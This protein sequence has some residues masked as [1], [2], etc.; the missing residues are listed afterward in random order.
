MDHSIE[1]LEGNKV[2][3]TVAVPADEFE[4]AI[5]AAFRKLAREVRIPG[6]RPGKAPRR[7][8][9]ARF[10]P[11]VAREHAL[12]DGLPEF[13]A[14]AVVAEDLDT[15]AAPEIEITAGE[16]AGDVEFEAVV[17]VRPVVHVAGYDSL[18][19]ELDYAA[20]DDAAIT[21]QLDGLRERFA[22]LSDSSEP[23]VDGDYAQIDLEGSVDGAPVD[24][25]SATDFLYEVGSAMVTPALDAQLRGTGPGAIL[26]FTD[27]LPERFGEQAGTEVAFRVLVKDAKHKVLPELTDAW[28]G[29]VTEFQ[30]VD[31]LRDD[32][33]KRLDLVG[34]LQAQMA[35]RDRVLEELSGLVPVEAPEALVGQEMERRLHD[36][37][38]RLEA[39][40]LTIPQYL[41]ATGQDQQAFLDGVRAGATQAVLADLGLRSVVADQE[42]EATDEE[43]EDEVERLA[44]RMGEKPAKVRRDFDR[45][46]VLGAVRSDIARG[47]ALQYLV[48][49]AT[50]CD[51]DG[52]ELDLALPEAST[53]A[54]TSQTDTATNEEESEE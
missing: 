28:V 32:A 31:E 39:Q 35:L 51:R 34:R 37:L 4:P 29:E 40:G 52:N 25:L 15:I 48:E 14:D 27:A 53:D 19:V 42:I 18:R 26:E 21:A 7:L 12:K 3:L 38:H 30:T 45:R 46:G 2:K 44:E 8:L 1:Q 43:L 36:L 5:D 20:P 49:H 47:K 50:V 22:A 11:E 33:A 10:G 6:F 41:M 16:E 13:Y 24:A 17:E 9:E 23:I 54:A